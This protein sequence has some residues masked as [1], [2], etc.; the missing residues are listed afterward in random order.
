LISLILIQRW[1][2][3]VTGVDDITLAG[4][5]ITERK[6]EEPV[7]V[8]PAAAAPVVL[9]PAAAPVVLQPAAAPALQP[10]AAPVARA[11]AGF[12][13]DDV[14]GDAAPSGISDDH[15]SNRIDD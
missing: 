8:Q 1:Q 5:S 9:Q 14:Y 4:L 3:D 10:A 6:D 12:T 13:V 2:I 7:A 15:C 11:A